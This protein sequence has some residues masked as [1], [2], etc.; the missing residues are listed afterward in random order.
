MFSIATRE[1]YNWELLCIAFARFSSVLSVGGAFP[2]VP[3]VVSSILS[4]PFAAMIET[5]FST[6]SLLSVSEVCFFVID[7][8]Q[9]AIETI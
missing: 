7:T 6:M 2:A 9:T 5:E 1:L 4:I 3:D 8:V